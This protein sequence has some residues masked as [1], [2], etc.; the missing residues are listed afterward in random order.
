ME[1]CVDDWQEFADYVG[2]QRNDWS[3]SGV[4]KKV[5][6]SEVTFRAHFLAQGC[7]KRVSLLKKER[8]SSVCVHVHV[9]EKLVDD[10]SFVSLTKRRI[11]KF[12]AESFYRFFTGSFGHGQRRTPFNTT[13]THVKCFPEPWGSQPLERMNQITSSLP[14]LHKICPS[15]KFALTNA[16]EKDIVWTGFIAKKAIFPPESP[17]PSIARKYIDL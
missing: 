13:V 2:H 17:Q 3:G 11:E 9:W 6:R 5:A 15:G 12:V 16:A 14:L 8:L 4:P 1:E 7:M 10:R